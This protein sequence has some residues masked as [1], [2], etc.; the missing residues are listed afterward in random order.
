MQGRDGMLAWS[1]LTLCTVKSITVYK[2]WRKV[3]QL[4]SSKTLVSILLQQ[5]TENY[6][7]VCCPQTDSK[8]VKVLLCWSLEGGS[9]LLTAQDKAWNRYLHKKHPFP[10]W[11]GQDNSV[12]WAAEK[13]ICPLV[14]LNT[15][16]NCDGPEG[17]NKTREY[18]KHLHALD[19]WRTKHIYFSMR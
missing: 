12:Q 16:I 3:G 7:Q 19:I 1:L 17:E 9:L 8:K 6:F 18:E 4:Q 5:H 13:P 2:T 10:I 11:K 14:Y 15:T